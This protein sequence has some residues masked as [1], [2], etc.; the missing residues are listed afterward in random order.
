MNDKH[1]HEVGRWRIV[2]RFGRYRFGFHRIDGLSG[3]SA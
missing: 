2:I 1:V 3:A